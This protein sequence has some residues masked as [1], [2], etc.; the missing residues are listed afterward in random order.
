MKVQVGQH[1]RRLISLGRFLIILS[2][3]VPG[4]HCN[5]IFG[6]NYFKKTHSLIVKLNLLYNFNDFVF[7]DQFLAYVR[8]L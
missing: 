2:G 6:L 5:I 4:Y 3:Q 8:H 7:P 1:E